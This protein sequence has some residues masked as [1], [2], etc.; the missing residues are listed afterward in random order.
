MS[1]RFLSAV[2]L[3]F[4]FGLPT[5]GQQHLSLEQCRSMALG[6]N[7]DLKIAGKQAELAQRQ[8]AIA[9]THWLPSFSASATGMY[10]DRDF[11]MDLTLPT[12]V[13]NPRTGELKPNLL[14]NPVTGLPVY[15]SD[16]IPLF[17]MYAWLP[18]NISLSGA[19]MASISLEQ[20]V[21]VGGKILAGN[22]MAQIG[23]R[24][25]AVNLEL[26]KAKTIEETD[27]AYWTYVSVR[28]KVRLA[29]EAVKML[30][31]FVVL[32]QNSVNAGMKNRNTLLKAQVGL[33]NAL[34]NLQK[35][36]HG[37]Q[38]SRM[39]LCRITGLPFD[40]LIVAADTIDI[41]ADQS[42]AEG[43]LRSASPEKR[44]EYQLLQDNIELARQQERMAMAD[45]LPTAGVRA[46]YNQIGGIEM[47]GKDF[48]NTSFNVF[49]SVKIP[50]FHWGEG[51]HK[52]KSAKL[53]KEVKQLELD[54]YRQ[55]MQLEAE[56]AKLNLIQA[57]ERIVM[58]RKA[59]EQAAENLRVN[60]DNFEFGMTTIDEVLLAQTQWLQAYTDVI[61]AQA[62]L[63][64]K[65]TNWLLIIGELGKDK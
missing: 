1:R 52:I 45:F 11:K 26:K 25:A 19:Y 29:K 13:P 59:I 9:R 27:R 58:G 17:N 61:D 41:W 38:L 60:R 65:E 48:D 57:N 46:G 5:I 36:E 51:L 2:A 10:Q 55:L 21:F 39:D 32:A 37:L 22:K 54:K 44:P 7:E 35:A 28:S 3:I 50:I 42:L 62:D 34:L 43:I 8:R 20:P 24:M 16:G 14:L 56:Q 15:G 64:I 6:K 63:R 49:A 33:N 30:E 47:S 4:L 12:L 53:D 23:V 18:L 31:E 40:S